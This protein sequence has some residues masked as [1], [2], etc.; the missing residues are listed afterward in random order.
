M[1]A[2]VVET[3]LNR[4]AT[5]QCALWSSRPFQLSS[6]WRWTC[7]GKTARLARPPSRMTAY[8]N[9]TVQ[10]SQCQL[11]SRFSRSIRFLSVSPFFFSLRIFIWARCSAYPATSFLGTI[12]LSE[13]FLIALLSPLTSSL[14]SKNS[15]IWAQGWTKSSGSWPLVRFAFQER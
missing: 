6:L 10:P 2:E 5:F 15:L 1:A 4:T 9:F 11:C 7:D 8:R 12:Y 3:P 13:N 14:S